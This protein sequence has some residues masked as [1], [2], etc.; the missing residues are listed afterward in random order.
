MDFTIL[1]T[2]VFEL[3]SRDEIQ[4]LEAIKADLQTRIEEEVH[5]MRSFFLM[6]SCQFSPLSCLF[7]NV[8]FTFLYLVFV[9]H[10]SLHF[11][12]K[13]MPFCNKVWRNERMLCMC[14]V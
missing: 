1:V 6:N 14:V 11:S 5:V 2:V 3:V 7:P 9:L 12:P 13:A 8:L 10:V 4:R